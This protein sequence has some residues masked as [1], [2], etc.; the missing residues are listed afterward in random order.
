MQT[1][2]RLLASLLDALAPPCCAAC[3][4]PASGVFCSACAAALRAYPSELLD[5][6]PLLVG[7]HYGSPLSDAIVRFKYQGRAELAAGLGALVAPK[8]A[9]A[10]LPARSLLVPVPLH[11][12]RLALRGYN[13]AALL[14][15]ALSS[16]TGLP[17]APRLLLRSRETERQVG[18]SR[19]LRLTNADGAFEVNTRLLSQHARPA[20][21]V[22]V[23][24]VVTT[25][26]TVRACAQALAAG[27]AR[28]V[29]VA[30]IARAHA[31]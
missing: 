12:R 1:V 16:A 29:A 7:G 31:D 20:T 15:R 4:G 2:A 3:D 6:I 9:A 14:A 24:D 28:L 23:D 5:G 25:G 13:Q 11:A 17:C 8:L 26:S 10:R 18:K 30:A 19:E 27:G 22:L 21:V